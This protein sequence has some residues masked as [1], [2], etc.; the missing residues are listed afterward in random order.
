MTSLTNKERQAFARAHWEKN[1]GY[2]HRAMQAV[3]S[4]S[5]TSSESEHN[6][7]SNS[8]NQQSDHIPKQF[9]INNIIHNRHKYINAHNHTNTQSHAHTQANT[10]IL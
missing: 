1:H 10:N 2:I 3:F 9:N 8:S 7:S 5:D 4:D 6:Q